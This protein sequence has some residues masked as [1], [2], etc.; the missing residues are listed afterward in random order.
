ME[1]A[2]KPASAPKPAPKRPT[3]K[4]SAAK[5]NKGIRTPFKTPQRVS[6]CKVFISYSRHDE[7]LVKPLAGLLAGVIAKPLFL[8]I[9]SIKP[10]D[11]WP[12]AIED[13]VRASEVFVLCWCCQSKQSKFVRREIRLAVAEA[14]KRL[15]P[16]L[17]CSVPLPHRLADRQWVDLRGRVSHTCTGPAF[18]HFRTFNDSLV[19]DQYDKIHVL[20]TFPPFSRHKFQTDK[21]VQTVLKYFE[22]L[23]P[24]K[25]NPGRIEFARHRVG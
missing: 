5:L 23:R 16:V 2:S 24:Q 3:H 12:S 6:A 25:S 20:Q 19:F 17:F 21:V 1:K 14:N 15:I 8:D 22:T 10:G 9:D 18:R 7:K 4:T 13:A 11:T